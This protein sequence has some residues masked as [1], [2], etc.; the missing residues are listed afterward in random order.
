MTPVKNVI[1]RKSGGKCTI[2][3]SGVLD[4]FEAQH[5]L[6][7]AQKLVSQPK[8]TQLVLDMTAV[9]R[10][11]I[12]ALQIIHGLLTASTSS[13]TRI[14]MVGLSESCAKTA[15]LIGFDI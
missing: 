1:F 15:A 6:Q 5:F 13:G 7:A 3:A 10:M 9:E 2:T 8:A 14:E 12:T 11:D 4:I